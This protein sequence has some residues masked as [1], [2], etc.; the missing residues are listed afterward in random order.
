MCSAKPYVRL[1]SQA[2]KKES[3]QEKIETKLQ[4]AVSSSQRR[5]RVIEMGEELQLCEPLL[6][7][8]T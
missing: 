1:M 6:A 8:G 5:D 4:E 3:R 2:V 7:A